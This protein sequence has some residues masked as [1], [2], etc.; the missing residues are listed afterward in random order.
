M[1]IHSLTSV[2]GQA[3]RIWTNCQEKRNKHSR[4]FSARASVDAAIGV[5]RHRQGM[6][7][8]PLSPENSFIVT[9]EAT[10]KSGLSP[11]VEFENG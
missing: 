11:S 8:A 1:Q 10:E 2:D 6:A 3:R 4:E 5:G 7:M 9:I